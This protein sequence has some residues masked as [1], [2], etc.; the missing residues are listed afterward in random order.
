MKNLL[1]ISA[2][3]LSIWIYSFS[4][5]SV[6]RFDIEVSP[7][8]VKVWES[9]DVTIKAV[10]SNGSVVRDYVWDILI[11]SQNDN[12]A[13]FPG[14]LEGN[15]YQFKAGDAGVV[16]FENAVKFT[17]NGIQDVSVYDNN[18]YDI[19][20]YAE[21]E[22]SEWS[23]VTTTWE[24]NIMY[25]E[26]GITLWSDKVKVSGRTLKNHQVKIVL[27]NDT[28]KETISNS[29]WIYE[30]EISNI[31]SGENVIIAE[32][33]DADGKVIGSSKEVFFKIESNAPRFRSIQLNPELSEYNSEA[34]V[35]VTVEATNGLTTVN[36]IINDMV[37]KLTEQS[38]GS[39]VGNITTPKNAGEYKIDV[40]LRNELGIETKQN[41]VKAIKVKAV[42][43]LAPTETQQPVEVNCDDFQTE[44]EVRNIQSVKLKSKS[45]ISW[46]KVEK[47]TS[48]N[49]YKKDRNSENMVLIENVVENQYEII[50]QWD[51]VEYDDFAIKAVFK[52]DVC[53]VESVNYSS[54]TKVQTGP[55]EMIL[56]MILLSLGTGFFLLRRRN[57]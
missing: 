26:D 44:L 13:V 1:K 35:W 3:I 36:L 30:L 50:I 52:D 2:L 6:S 42:E 56:L 8:K 21:V 16:K 57:A 22:V 54:M 15:I 38:A 19:Y 7:T 33:M 27:N 34:L 25:P 46:D 4:Y 47:A 29:E 43:F 51:L 40:V 10:D 18:D 11:F 49:V 39:Y 53:N 32:V 48:Y 24:I 20:G 5:A 28:Q 23:T 55:K 37:T 9:V 17:K 14:I 12:Q 31:P 45:V 41:G